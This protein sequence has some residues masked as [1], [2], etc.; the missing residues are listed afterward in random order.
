MSISYLFLALAIICEVIGTLLLPLSNNFT[1]ILP[2][3]GILAGY[4]LAFYFMTFALNNIPLVIVYAS[5]A[6]L[7]V[8]LV[9]L[10]SFLFYDQFIHW[11]AII[12]LVLIIVGVVL[13][14][15]HISTNV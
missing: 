13:V 3:T 7:G 5:W 15:I 8:A 14:N 2:T 6:G 1:R 10:F 11:Q 4:S 12:G 9:T